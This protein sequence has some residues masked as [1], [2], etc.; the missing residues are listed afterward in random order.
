V[1]YVDVVYAVA[2]VSINTPAGFP[3]L[4]RAGTHW[5]ANDPIVLAN[6]TT[7][8]S[9]PRVGMSSTLPIPQGDIEQMTA[10]PGE[11]RSARQGY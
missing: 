11:K 9:D 7:F 10:A 5:P 1:L 4:V 6:P 2:T 3:V 8:S